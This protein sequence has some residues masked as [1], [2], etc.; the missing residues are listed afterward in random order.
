MRPRRNP[1]LGRDAFLED[2][3]PSRE[4]AVGSQG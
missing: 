1:E 2:I 4:A 3:D